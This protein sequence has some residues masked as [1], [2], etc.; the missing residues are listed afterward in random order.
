M[1]TLREQP[2]ARNDYN[3]WLASWPL[4]RTQLEDQLAPLGYKE[5]QGF[6]DDLEATLADIT[7]LAC[8]APDELLQAQCEQCHRPLNLSDLAQGRQ[9]CYTCAAGKKTTS[10][11][12][13]LTA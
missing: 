10:Y 11:A 4:I 9:R 12:V 2:M 1:I 5:V 3:L 13:S 6:L 7:R 8:I